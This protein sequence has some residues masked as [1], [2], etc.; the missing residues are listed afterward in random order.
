MHE[1]SMFEKSDL[2]GAKAQKIMIARNGTDAGTR[3][4]I[5]MKLA[6][7]DCVFQCRSGESWIDHYSF[8]R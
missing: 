3:R 6:G 2:F 4:E 5:I 1:I 8:H 7:I